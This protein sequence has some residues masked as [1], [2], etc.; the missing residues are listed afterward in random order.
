[1]HYMEH[2]A[3][4]EHLAYWEGFVEGFVESFVNERLKAVSK[5][6][7]REETITVCRKLAYILVIK[8]MLKEDIS[9]N[10]IA[11]VTGWTQ[12]QILAIVNDN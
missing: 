12:E 7:E 2:I 8:K 3:E 5:N 6:I 4:V 11:F 10:T 1:M 9:I